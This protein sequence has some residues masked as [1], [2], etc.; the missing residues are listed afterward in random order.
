MEKNIQIFLFKYVLVFLHSYFLLTSYYLWK[1]YLKEQCL[2]SWKYLHVCLN[3][4]EVKPC[5]CNLWRG[6]WDTKKLR[7]LSHKT[8]HRNCKTE[9]DIELCAPKS[10]ENTFDFLNT[11]KLS[12]STAPSFRHS[13]TIYLVDIYVLRSWHGRVRIWVYRSSKRFTS[14][15]TL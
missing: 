10:E 13:L 15:H 14:K 8:C 3:F 6:D 1:I 12:P 4:S 2:W 9:P 7:N 11:M 5:Y